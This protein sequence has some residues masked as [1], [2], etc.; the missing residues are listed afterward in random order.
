M[1]REDGGPRPPTRSPPSTWQPIQQVF[2]SASDYLLARVVS[3]SRLRLL[4]RT[5]SFRHRSRRL[6]KE[7]ARHV[8]PSRSRSWDLH[9]HTSLRPATCLHHCSGPPG[10]VR[11]GV[12][13][14]IHQTLPQT[15]QWLSYAIG[16]RNAR[17][18]TVQYTLHPKHWKTRRRLPTRMSSFPPPTSSRLGRQGH[19]Y[20]TPVG[21]P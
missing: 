18:R 8:G 13:G 9:T 7:G 15:T 3:A 11:F 16:V 5:S 19:R 4:V 1:G 20:T 12:R 14:R 6:R 21:I 2:T 10:P 17:Q